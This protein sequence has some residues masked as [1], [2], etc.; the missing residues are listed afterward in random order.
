M[1]N[2]TACEQRKRMYQGQRQPQ[3][4]DIGERAHEERPARKPE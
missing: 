4:V 1:A 3:S 2:M